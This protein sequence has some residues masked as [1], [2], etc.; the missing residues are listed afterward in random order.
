MAGGDG[1]LYHGGGVCIE[2]AR[3]ALR[4]GRYIT[5]GPAKGLTRTGGDLPPTRLIRRLSGPP[6]PLGTFLESYVTAP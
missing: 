5:G 1:T 6:G 4:R 2:H 3:V